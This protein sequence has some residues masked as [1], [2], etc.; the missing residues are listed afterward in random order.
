MLCWSE[1]LWES[2]NGDSNSL[3]CE[4]KYSC[5]QWH[6]VFCGYIVFYSHLVLLVRVLW[7]GYFTIW[8]TLLSEFCVWCHDFNEVVRQAPW[9]WMKVTI[10][11]YSHVIQC[12]V[13]KWCFVLSSFGNPEVVVG[14]L[15]DIETESWAYQLRWITKHTSVDSCLSLTKKSQLVQYYNTPHHK[16]PNH[17]S[18]SKHLTL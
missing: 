10:S 13:V 7:W 6:V 1:S 4:G 9:F 12:Q 18:E 5:L 16:H 17:A 2:G 8:S 3:F 15:G 14:F 11:I